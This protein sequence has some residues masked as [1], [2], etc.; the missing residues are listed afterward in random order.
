MKPRRLYLASIAL[1]LLLCAAHFGIRTIAV[2]SDPVETDLYALTWSF[3]L[4]AFLI[5]FF[6]LWLLG[7]ILLLSVEVWFVRSTIRRNRARQTCS[8]AT[9]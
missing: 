7:L 4:V 2:L 5:V 1:W 6:P 3:Q 8:T 9:L